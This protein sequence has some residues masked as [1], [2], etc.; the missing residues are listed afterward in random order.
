MIEKFNLDWALEKIRE[1][2]A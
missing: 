1:V 2:L